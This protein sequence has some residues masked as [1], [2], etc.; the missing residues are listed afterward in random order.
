MDTLN[1]NGPLNDRI[2][3]LL[4]EVNFGDAISQEGFLQLYRE[5]R[6]SYECQENASPASDYAGEQDEEVK[7][8]CTQASLLF[9]ARVLFAAQAQ[10]GRT[11]SNFGCPISRIVAAAGINLLDFFRE[12][13][14]VV[15][16]LSSYFEARGGSSRLFAQQAQLKENSETVVVMGLLA[17]KYK[18][19]FG[20]LLHQLDFFKQIVLKLGWNAFLVL[21]IKLLSSFP[22]VVSCVELLPCVFA[23]LVSHAPQLPDCLSHVS[24]AEYRSALLKSLSEICKAD[25]SRVQA[26]I[27]SVE[28]LLSHVL[29]SAVPEWRE[30]ASHAQLES[31]LA[32]SATA[33]EKCTFPGVV[34]LVSSRLLEGL[35]TDGNRMQRALSALETEY[36]QHYT[37]GGSEL[38]EREFLFTDFTKFASPR[39][40]P[41]HMQSAVM[42]L[43]AGPLPIRQ[44]SLLGPG[45]HTTA[46]YAISPS[47]MNPKT[48]LLARMH[49][50][51]PK[52]NLGVETGP[53]VTPVSEIMST[54]AWLRGITASLAAEPS[55]SVM[56]YLA[57]VAVPPDGEQGACVTVTLSA[58]EQLNQ[59]VQELVSCI[60]PEEK[61]PSLLGSFPL[62]QPSLV[63]ERRIEV[64]KVYY[65][66]LERILQAEEKNNG[67]AGVTSLL[68]AGKFHRALVACSAEVVTA[69]YR[70]V[71]CTFPKVLDALHI[72]AFDLAK[73]IQCFVRSITTLP[74]DLKRHLFLVE[75][76]ILESL[77]WEADSP[78]YSLIC[79][80]VAQDELLEEC[81]TFE[82]DTT[83]KT[84]QAPKSLVLIPDTSA[85]PLSTK[86]PQDSNVLEFSPVKKARMEGSQ[87]AVHRYLR[88]LPPCIG[89]KFVESAHTDG[90]AAA[91]NHFCCKVLKL[92]AFRLAVL[93]DNFDFSPLQRL[94]VN[95]KVYQTIEHALFFQTHLFYNRHIDQIILSALYGFCKVHR[96][97]QVSFREIIAHYR[98]QPQAQPSIFRSVVVEQSNPSLQVGRRADIIAFYNQVFV[99]CMKS[100]LLRSGKGEYPGT[101]GPTIGSPDNVTGELKGDISI[102]CGAPAMEGELSAA[103][104]SAGKMTQIMKQLGLE[105]LRS[106]GT[107]HQRSHAGNRGVLM[108]FGVPTDN[109]VDG[110]HVMDSAQNC[111]ALLTSAHEMEVR[112]GLNTCT[113]GKRTEHQIPDGLAA[114]LQALDS[115][116]GGADNCGTESQQYCE[117]GSRLNAGPGW[118]LRPVG[119]DG[120]PKS[121]TG[122]DQSFN[123]QA[124]CA[125]LD[126]FDDAD[127]YD[128]SQFQKTCRR[129]RT[130]NRKHGS[131]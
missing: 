95:T 32:K 122:L 55:P 78:L 116:Q 59:R 93:C 41:R 91:L 106:P 53:P 3:F 43:R 111:A 34:D 77:A 128:C 79:S 35:V 17:K 30:A 80:T 130:P 68:S 121:C 2:S 74:R 48:S 11:V 66:S 6:A 26:R 16:K 18:D 7:H 54:S 96:L 56:R 85:S 70:M 113:P 64:T 19:N 10:G 60:M 71:S 5:L 12:V 49:S 124:A 21:R 104:D 38:D 15:S 13:N 129:Q 52:L 123:G 88:K 118:V 92:A 29:T 90:C 99:P 46:S 131:D 75:E 120:G 61:I 40:S 25:Y 82:D 51:L 20:M 47:S 108:R 42:K 110:V 1:R 105:A 87:H 31:N 76:K 83:D 86:R 37:R 22:D 102:S 62:L 39:F 57:E 117:V 9:V 126:V 23:I 67:V 100:F 14:V 89:A 65:L 94:D 103:H 33:A 8:L 4:K 84:M 63:S 107:E 119:L 69:C 58:A 50:P 27:P 115:Q 44:G 97:A 81:A 114:L 28:A 98:K 73:M 125:G 101:I 45:A 24:G 112:A 72:K 127:T 109:A 36:A